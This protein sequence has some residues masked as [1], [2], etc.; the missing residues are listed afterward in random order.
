MKLSQ[1][2]TDQAADVLV[3]IAEPSSNIMHDEKV[4]DMLE[5]LAKGNTDSAV[6]FFADNITMVVTALLK[7]HRADVYEIVA[8]V[9]NKTV[10]EVSTQ[11]IKQTISD[12]KDS[13]D[14]ELLDFF[15]SL[16]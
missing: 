6:K 8:A 10:E 16:K 3:R 12:I 15:G 4:Y 1:M 5:K 7:D 14:G 2:T 9:A 13:W 11:N